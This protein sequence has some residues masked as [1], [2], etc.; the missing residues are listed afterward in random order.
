[1]VRNPPG[2]YLM[3]GRAAIVVP[4]GDETS[5]AAAASRYG[6]KYLAIE[7]AGASGPI[8]AV[9]KNQTSERLQYLGNVDG[10]HIF[11]SRPLGS[12]DARLSS[13][14]GSR[15]LAR[16]SICWSARRTYRIG[17][18]LDNSWIHLTYARNLAQRGEWSFQPGHLS[19]GST[20]PLWTFL[21]A[22]GF[23]LH[24]GPYVWT[25]LLGEGCLIG[26]ALLA[27]YA[28]RRLAPAYRPHMPW[29]GAFFVAEWHL[30]WAALSG[31]EI[32]L[33]ALLMTGV[34]VALMAGS[35]SYLL[36]G[37]LTGLSL[38]IRP[39]GLTL[40]GPVLVTILLV[41]R[42]ISEKASAAVTYL[43]GFAALCVPYL[44]FNVWLSGAPLPNTFYAK[45]A[46][47][48]AWQAQ[49]LLYR[50]G[51]LVV[52]LLTGPGLILA[53]G[54]VGAVV[55]ALRRRAWAT[56][57]A[58]AW[59]GGY[60]LL[61]ILRLPVYQHG[62]YL[63]PAMPVFFLF[64]LLAYVEFRNSRAFWPEAMGDTDHRPA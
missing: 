41:E 45:Q 4:F 15:R 5:I 23:W 43:T 40:L 63:I 20:A 48:A 39:D 25:Y 32:L 60:L 34:L 57:A 9:Y 12:R 49:P 2:Y 6:A 24:V 56:L 8:E 30:Q 55:L 46:E 17:F 64:G 1:M 38:W 29:I 3:T 59:C 11:Q 28:V 36:L 52:Q 47:Y 10:T 42:G 16:R 62:R 7:A 35:R 53:P 22:I 14:Q 61:Y 27:E 37:L 44:A 50:L 26:L 31:M 13:S 18:P 51:V 33:Q 54:V 21:L 58:M 19:A